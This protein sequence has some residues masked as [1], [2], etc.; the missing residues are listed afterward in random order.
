MKRVPRI[1]KKLKP[2]V[3]DFPRKLSRFEIDKIKLMMKRNLAAVQ[4]GF[5][6]ASSSEKSSSSSTS[7]VCD[8]AQLVYSNLASW[9]IHVAI[10]SLYEVPL[11]DERVDEF[12]NKVFHLPLDQETIVQI[13]ALLLRIPNS[14][15][16]CQRA[17]QLIEHLVIDRQLE[18]LDDSS[19]LTLSQAVAQFGASDKALD[20]LVSHASTMLHA[21][22][23][24]VLNG[25][26]IR[27]RSEYIFPEIL[28]PCL[29]KP[30]LV[31]LLES[32]EPCDIPQI[33]ARTVDLVA[34]EL[35]RLSFH[36]LVDDKDR[37]LKI[38][39]KLKLKLDK[40]VFVENNPFYSKKTRQNFLKFKIFKSISS[41]FHEQVLSLPMPQVAQKMLLLN[42]VN[43][44][45]LDSVD[46]VA[47][48]I[49]SFGDTLLSNLNPIEFTSLLYTI[50]H[51]PS[52]WKRKDKYRS[53]IGT[54]IARVLKSKID[55]LSQPQ[56][57]SCVQSVMLYHNSAIRTLVASDIVPRID[58]SQIQSVEDQIAIGKLMAKL[59]S[60]S[61]Q[62]CTSLLKLF[63]SIDLAR[64]STPQT[65]ELMDICLV[66]KMVNPT[67]KLIGHLYSRLSANGG[68]ISPPNVSRVLAAI[69]NLQLRNTE[70]V[71]DV[72][73]QSLG[74]P[75]SIHPRL[76]AR[77]V[78]DIALFSLCNPGVD[79][80]WT[81][82]ALLSLSVPEN[83]D[84]VVSDSTVSKKFASTVPLLGHTGKVYT[85]HLA[86]V[87]GNALESLLESAQLEVTT[88]IDKEEWTGLLP[89][90]TSFIGDMLGALFE[91]G[92]LNSETG[93]FVIESPRVWRNEGM[94]LQ[95]TIVRA[96]DCA[97]DDPR[98]ILARAA[99]DIARDRAQG[100]EVVVLPEQAV[101]NLMINGSPDD[102]KKRI[103]R[104]RIIHGNVSNN[105]HRLVSQLKEI[106]SE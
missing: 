10:R 84:L 42:G 61:D 105:T 22:S 92:P 51:H 81:E 47:N 97:R 76:L 54:V 95:V 74:D 26:T 62:A 49:Q 48:R 15:Q 88:K 77:L 9:P 4:T 24:L 8:R 75:S 67:T 14:A 32:V 37:V 90:S 36:R 72:L 55:S 3:D 35:S 87:P 40:Q 91:S 17:T 83:F 52:A 56:L 89:K 71:R 34:D 78:S 79:K 106:F 80:S 66:A 58:F 21:P 53:Q 38:L 27:S 11:D 104:A 69:A 12:F 25:V 103:R 45:K 31:Q 43:S 44:L 7:T 13:L 33:I 19:M 20:I 101:D 60:G 68:L 86:V 65:V 50:S 39:F 23:L 85:D 70:S 30:E 41:S 1:T 6:N 5:E 46:I 18:E 93:G 94:K 16:V 96:K 59:A 63:E 102:V 64:L 57:V 98:H 2:L 100:W 29:S 82:S 28:I 73:V 99:K